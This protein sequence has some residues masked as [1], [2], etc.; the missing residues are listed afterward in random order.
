MS[1]A[2]PFRI[3][4]WSPLPPQES[5]ISDYSYDLL[6]ELVTKIALVAV[7]RDD[8]V[9]RVRAPEGVDVI[10]ATRYLTG[11]AGRY[12][13]DVYQMGNHPWFHGYM[14]QAALLTPGLLVLHDVALLDFYAV[15]VGGMDSPV[16]FEEARLDEA[17]LDDLKTVDGLP[18]IQLDGRTEPDR[19]AVPLARRLVEASLMTIVHSAALRDNLLE[20]Y[21]TA[22]VRHVNQPA[23]ILQP[24]DDPQTGAAGEVVFGIFGSLER[25]KRVAVAVKAFARVH[26]RYPERA[27]LVIAG[28][29]DN[30]A[31][32]REVRRIIRASNMAGAVRILTD[33]PLEELEAQIARS[34]VVICLRW[35]TAGEVSASLMRAL[36]AGKPVIASDVLQYRDLDPSFCWKVTT[37]PSAEQSEIEV[38][39]RRVMEDPDIARRAGASAR[40]F[41]ETEATVS[42]SAQH[43]LEAIEMCSA[44][45]T[46]AA[47]L[48]R[49]GPAPRAD[50]PGVNV[51]ADWQATTGLAE[52]ARRSVGALIEAGIDVA[53][54]EVKEAYAPRDPRRIPAWLEGLPKGRFHQIDIC[55]L[56]VN[57]LSLISDEELH[58]RGSDGYVIGYWFWELP[59]VA[60]AFVPA[61]DRVDEIW[62]GSRFT[63]EA[64]L[65][66]TDKPVHVMPC[67][68][69]A[70]PSVPATRKDL[71]LPEGSCLFLFHFDAFSTFARKNP[72]AVIN[73]FRRAFTPEERAARVRLVLKTINLSRCPPAAGE[74]IV[75]EMAQVDGILLDTDL[76]GAE[77]SSLIACSDVYVSLHRSEGFG[78]GIAEAMLAGRPAIA[79][80]Y[81]GNLDFTTYQNSCLV[82]YRLTPVSTSEI[83]FN[84]GMEI[85]YE[86]EQLWADAD[87]GQAA[88]WMRAL[89]ENPGLRERLGAAGA[90]TIQTRYN[91]AVAGAAAA[92]RLKRI[93]A[94]RRRRRPK[95]SKTT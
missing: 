34:D 81:S 56:N 84:P 85:V 51:I 41:V 36:G 62:V 43:Y 8:V 20:R 21:P 57:E 80:A 44:L 2:T 37:D 70:P 78:L 10:G 32:E 67:V 7:V 1:K 55:Y 71:G 46:A 12:D 72:W 35:P 39:M 3:A 59:S 31:V 25:H 4:W 95:P 29:L 17:R 92:A 75:R 18:S 66:H 33:L 28:R 15:V 45:R 58:P 65:G 49:K 64:F 94:M 73:A 38:L 26:D 52:A 60:R 42:A 91:S 76:S 6:E 48:A 53:A 30:P 89:Y 14:H 13:L 9:G 90:A 87:V 68:V 11:L 77:M 93:A 22:L 24:P 5:G 63:Q 27:R 47:A 61:I 23:R 83:Q 74:R 88:R 79:T 19:L 82:G 69:T 50:V 16:L 40:H 54:Q 86:P